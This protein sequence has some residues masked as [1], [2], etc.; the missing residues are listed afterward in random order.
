ML[1]QKIEQISFPF[2]NWKIYTETWLGGSY[3]NKSNNLITSSFPFIHS[4]TLSPSLSLVEN[5]SSLKWE[6][7]E[8]RVTNKKGHLFSLAFL[9]SQQKWN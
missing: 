1:K 2:F 5:K 3:Q 8:E 7:G 6:T 9:C 4:L